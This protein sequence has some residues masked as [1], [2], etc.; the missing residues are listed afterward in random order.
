MILDILGLPI[1]ESHIVHNETNRNMHLAAQ[2][3]LTL[4][5]KGLHKMA[6]HDILI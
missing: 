2:I 5:I 1:E 4:T 6:L 3:V